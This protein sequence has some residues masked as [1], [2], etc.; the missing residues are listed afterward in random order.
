MPT[1]LR[2][3]HPC[4]AAQFRNGKNSHVRTLAQPGATPGHGHDWPIADR[5]HQARCTRAPAGAKARLL[6]VVTGFGT[7]TC[8]KTKS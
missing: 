5:D 6:K 3:R 8:D 1:P 7:K 4:P 2:N